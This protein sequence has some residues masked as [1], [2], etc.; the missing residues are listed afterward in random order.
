M[1]A[2][3]PRASRRAVP[4]A[5]EGV[6]GRVAFT[7]GG[8]PFRW[9]DVVAA[10][11]QYG[12]WAEAEELTRT[13]L[14]CH[15]R[16]VSE[17]EEVDRRELAVATERFRRGNDLLAADDVAAWLRTWGVSDGELRAHLAQ[18]LLRERFADELAETVAR[19]P[20]GDADVAA[21]LWPDAVCAGILARAARR[22]ADDVA[23]A[24]SAGETAGAGDEAI[25]RARE[26]ADRVRAEAVTDHGLEREV[27]RH[28]L[29]WLRIDGVAVRAASEDVAREIALCVR[30]DGRAL[31]EVAAGAGLAAGSFRAYAVDLPADLAP[32]VV[33]ARPTELVGPLAW[34]DG[35]AL[36]LVEAKTPPSLTDPDV[37]SRARERV[38]GRLAE[39]A[40]RDHVEW[41]ERL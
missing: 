15:A 27:D 26:T 19:H 17:G 29:E 32:R 36:L 41:H 22:L 10:A 1:A 6:A 7:A 12:L 39:R 5:R 37:R 21:A 30:E 2:A 11:V 18:A 20:A 14:A 8:E 24:V 3:F 23:L 35:F 40:V 31:G 16:L 4:A 38:L 28:R 25:A 9:A 13:G 33:A 34:E